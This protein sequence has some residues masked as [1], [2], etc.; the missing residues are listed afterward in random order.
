M[1][2]YRKV[3]INEALDTVTAHQQNET[4]QLI[5]LRAPHSKNQFISAYNL[6]GLGWVPKTAFGSGIWKVY[7]ASGVLQVTFSGIQLANDVFSYV[8][9][10]H[11]PKG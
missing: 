9:Y 10:A 2:T 1:R 5:A 11:H 3:W 6:L 8:D 4:D 7:D